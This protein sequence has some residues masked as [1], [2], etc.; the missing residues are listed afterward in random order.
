[1]TDRG[2]WDETIVDCP[3]CGES[4]LS[5]TD[6]DE[7]LERYGPRK[8]LNT[9]YVPSFILMRDIITQARKAITAEAAIKEC[10]EVEAEA[11]A[12]VARLTALLTRTGGWLIRAYVYG[13]AD[14]RQHPGDDLAEILTDLEAWFEAQGIEAKV[15]RSFS[16]REV[17]YEVASKRSEEILEQAGCL[18]CNAIT[19]YPDC[20]I[21]RLSATGDS[22]ALQTSED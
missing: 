19:A 4:K 14:S 20:P 13:W 1:M 10:Q 12:K 18:G 15:P 7:I 22:D 21:C 11:E 5:D 2:D 3:H 9:K 16:N 6:L 17:F 8:Y